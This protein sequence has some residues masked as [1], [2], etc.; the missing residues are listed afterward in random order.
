[1]EILS[2]GEK[3][4]RARVYKGYTLKDVC[5]DKISVSKMSCIENNKIEPEKW[6]LQF[7]SKRLDMDLDYLKQDI[8]EQLIN[9]IKTL[10]ENKKDTKYESD[11]K[12][13][14]QYAEKYKYFDLA[15][16]IMHK[17]FNY[18]IDN[19]K[20]DLLE[21]F[22]SK[23]YDIY[24]KAYNEEN[25]CIYYI[26]KAKYL[27]INQEFFQAAGYY[28]NVRESLGNKRNKT[29]KEYERLIKVAYNEAACNVMLKN[30]D[31]AYNIAINLLDL[32]QF[33]DV[34]LR[35]A[36]IFHMLAML[37]LRIDEE[38]FK[39]YEKKSYEFYKDNYIEKAYAMNN[40]AYGMFEVGYKKKGLEYIKKGLEY[41]PKDNKKT[42]VEYMLTSID[43]LIEND[44]INEGGEFCDEALNYS[45]ELDE[46]KFIER[47][48][49]FK[50]IILQSQGSYNSAEMYMNFSLDALLK[51]GSKQ[52]I[53]KR[54]M[55][56][57]NMYYKL[58]NVSD[59]LK[60]FSLA[61]KLE[62]KI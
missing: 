2:T 27:Y 40:Y 54:Y 23:Y 38:K 58:N 47:A 59:S 42:L 60:F 39:E 32:L 34:D 41:Y 53:Y 9:N 56:M 14:L 7:I 43:T 46:I 6:I 11:L 26:D 28:E 44:F 52:D 10:E 18:Y 3:I 36:E 29:N 15:I 55:E 35:K 31:R 22:T 24:Q 8:K 61:L 48:Y 62:D 45:I 20:M 21:I 4:K 25:K 16:K 30:Y 12:Y 19:D 57:G 33:V 51:F 49:Y 50:S 37:S 17:L 5:E 13:N 1:M